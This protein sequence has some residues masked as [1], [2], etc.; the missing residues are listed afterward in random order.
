MVLD[1]CSSVVRGVARRADLSPAEILHILL[2]D[3]AIAG[4]KCQR[5]LLVWG[6]VPATA[7]VII[8]PR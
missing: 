5:I 8:E 1:L 4:E 6:Y 2:A 3:K 7:G